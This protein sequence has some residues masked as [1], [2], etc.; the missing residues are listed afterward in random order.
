MGKIVRRQDMITPGGN[1][2]CGECGE[3]GGPGHRH[4][5][6]PGGVPK[7][8][9]PKKA[10]R[11]PTEW[12]PRGDTLHERVDQNVAA[13]K[14][15]S[16]PLNYGSLVEKAEDLA[17]IEANARASL[18]VAMER[19]GL[20]PDERG[21]RSHWQLVVEGYGFAYP[22][23]F[24]HPEAPDE[25]KQKGREAWK[26]VVEIASDSLDKYLFVK[27]W[28]R[29]VLSAATIK[30]L[31]GAPFQVIGS[32]DPEDIVEAEIVE[33]MSDPVHPDCI[34]MWGEVDGTFQIT[35]WDEQCP[36]HGKDLPF[37]VV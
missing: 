25:V 27:V 22:E 10:E 6:R 7:P 12:R 15:R 36:A 18:I 33:E 35:G 31:E 1:P 2:V 20:T 13:T 24:V 26:R 5:Y 21:I 17:G 11:D 3:V 9:E 37:E 16:E 30:A 4:N 14:M 34:C 29:K 32:D 19:S 28:R 8:Y 23:G